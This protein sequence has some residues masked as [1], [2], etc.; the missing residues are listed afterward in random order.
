MQQYSF[1]EFLLV[2]EAVN[3]LMVELHL[4]YCFL[5]KDRKVRICHVQKST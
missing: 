3:N 1:V 5:G 2:N 4:L